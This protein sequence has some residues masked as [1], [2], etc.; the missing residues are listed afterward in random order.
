M[1]APLGGDRLAVEA[2]GRATAPPDGGLRGRHRRAAGAGQAA[3]PPPTTYGSRVGEGAELHW[4][5]EQLDLRARQR[6]ARHHPGRPRRHRPA[7]AARGAG[8]R[9]ARR[10][11]PAGSPAASPSAGPGGRCSTSSW[12]TG[13]ERPGGW[14]GAAVLGR[15]PRR[16]PTPHRRPR[17]RGRPVAARGCSATAPRS[18]RWPGPPP[19]HRARR[20]RPAAAAV[21]DEALDGLLKE[22]RP[23][24]KRESAQRDRS[25]VI[26]S[27][28]KQCTP[29]SQDLTDERIPRDHDA[30]RRH[31]RR[32]TQE[33]GSDLRRTS[34]ARFGRH[35]DQRARS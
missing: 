25:P 11:R 7:G 9:P 3:Y 14:D 24:R 30:T 27:V 31:G 22:Q 13:P 33:G 1:S 18:P 23:S 28:K 32:I 34:G 6:P 29:C 16:R 12:P 10:G 2:A 8:P 35:S 19:G 17:V 15:P 21:L 20:R 4:L 26:G 5:P